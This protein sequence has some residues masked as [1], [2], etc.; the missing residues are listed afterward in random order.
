MNENASNGLKKVYAR[1]IIWFSHPVVCISTVNRIANYKFSPSTQ[2]TIQFELNWYK[3]RKGGERG[4]E[5]K[6]SIRGAGKSRS[7]LSGKRRGKGR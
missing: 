2:D 1:S 4:E 3:Q 5:G 7:W 6:N